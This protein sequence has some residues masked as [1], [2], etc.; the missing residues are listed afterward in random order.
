MNEPRTRPDL[1]PGRV[2]LTHLRR[3]L[4]GL[5][6]SYRIYF[7]GQRVGRL[8]RGK[9]KSYELSTGQH[10][11]KIKILYCDSGDFPVRVAPG[12]Q[13]K[14]TCRARPYSRTAV[15]DHRHEWVLIDEVERVAGAG[16]Q[17]SGSRRSRRP[18]TPGAG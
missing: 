13:V 6:A 17:A 5:I 7:D 11:L 15:Y 2:T 4:G 3:P 16:G 1:P 14:L 9:T 18:R 12:E 10:V 8:G